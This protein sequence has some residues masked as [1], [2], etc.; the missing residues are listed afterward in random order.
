MG[1]K[2]KDKVSLSMLKVWER[3]I[4]DDIEWKESNV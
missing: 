2:Y 1:V 3:I 4:L